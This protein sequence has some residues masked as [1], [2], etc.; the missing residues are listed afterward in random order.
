LTV[1]VVDQSDRTPV[2]DGAIGE[3]VLKGP[4]VS[5]GYWSAPIERVMVRDADGSAQ[6]YLATGD[7]GA[8]VGGELAVVGRIKDI[9]IINGANF[10]AEDIEATVLSATYELAPTICAVF[11]RGD[12]GGERLIVALEISRSVPVEHVELLETLRVIVDERH[13]VMVHDLV[14]A[15]PGHLPRTS[16]GKIRRSACRQA[17]ACGEL[18]LSA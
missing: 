5:D 14:I 18:G 12:Q 8:I 15:K 10:H 13:G 11:G 16:S 2:C 4:S 9:V 17:Y 7:L 6:P 3:I 1:H